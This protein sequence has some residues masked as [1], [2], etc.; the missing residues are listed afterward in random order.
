[1]GVDS[2]TFTASGRGR[3][4]LEGILTGIVGSEV[5]IRSG[6]ALPSSSSDIESSDIGFPIG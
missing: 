1:M 6:F 2:E 4:E 5:R 3:E